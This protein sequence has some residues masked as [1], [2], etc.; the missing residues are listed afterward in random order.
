[1]SIFVTHKTPLYLILVCFPQLLTAGLPPTSPQGTQADW[2]GLDL[3]ALQVQVGRSLLTAGSD[4]L[5]IQG[6]E[7]VGQCWGSHRPP[8]ALTPRAASV[9]GL[10]P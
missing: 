2:G 3:R 4:R 9:S 6:E 8:G 1:M 7:G 10:C 5:F